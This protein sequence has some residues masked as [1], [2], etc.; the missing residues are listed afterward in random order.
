ML[1]VVAFF[2][3]CTLMPVAHVLDC[4]VHAV[5]GAKNYFASA[6]KEYRP[7]DFLYDVQ[8]TWQMVKGKRG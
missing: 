2:L 3:F 4:C 8:N 5:R 1:R 7:R 6:W